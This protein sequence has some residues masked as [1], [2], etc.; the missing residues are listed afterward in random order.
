MENENIIDS[1]LSNA[2]GYNAEP[3]SF[4]QQTYTQQDESRNRNQAA[5]IYRKEMM[6]KTAQEGQAFGKK[7]SEIEANYKK[8]TEAL[9]AEVAAL[10]A[11]QQ[12]VSST[13]DTLSNKQLTDNI[14]AEEKALSQHEILKDYFDQTVVRNTFLENLKGDPQKGIAPK[15]LTPYESLAIA[16]FFDLAKENQA[17]KS[18]IRRKKDLQEMVFDTEISPHSQVDRFS[19]VKDSKSAKEVA[20]ELAREYDG[21]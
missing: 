12:S 1:L 10:K 3:D 7:L 6:Q 17:L 19:N 11:G 14:L 15:E 20:L 21:N 13:I 16:K 8:E 2:D 5:E 18:Q 4:T 9:K